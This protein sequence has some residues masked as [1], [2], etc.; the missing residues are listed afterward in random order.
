MTFGTTRTRLGLFVRGEVCSWVL[1]IDS[2]PFMV[3]VGASSE[4]I[5]TSTGLIVT[6]LFGVTLFDDSIYSSTIPLWVG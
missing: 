4:S 5:S 2:A 6:G 3:S 1:R